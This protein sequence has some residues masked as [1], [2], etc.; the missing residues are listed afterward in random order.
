MVFRNCLGMMA[1]VSMLIIGMGAA[2]PVKVVNFSIAV[3]KQM[4]R[5]D[6]ARELKALL[7]PARLRPSRWRRR[8]LCVARAVAE[9]PAHPPLDPRPAWRV[10]HPRE[11]VRWRNGQAGKKEVVDQRRLF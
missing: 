11:S 7:T 2:T 6:N 1:S 8:P 4:P 9:L 3:L 5:V 10:R